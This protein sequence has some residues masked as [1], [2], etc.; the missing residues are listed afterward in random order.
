MS[1]D[2]ALV[3]K[4]PEQPQQSSIFLDSKLN[5]QAQAFASQLASS[6]LVPEAYQGQK[7]HFN[8]MI[9]IEMANRMGLSPL[10]VMQNLTIVRGKPSWSASF[11]IATIQGCGRFEGFK[12]NISGEGDTLAVSCSATDVSTGLEV[13]G[14][15][16]SLETAKA[17]GWARSNKKYQTMPEVMLRYRAASA[18]GRFYIS[19]LL[20][21][22][23]KVEDMSGIDI[24]TIDVRVETPQNPLGVVNGLAARTEVSQE[25]APADSED[26]F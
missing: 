22:L 13:V 20:L 3:P 23:E 6:A 15:V 19:D 1:D 7:G 18:F 8:C 25:Q 12:Y 21:G 10:Q 14:P 11:I 16:V 24:E 4:Q 26:I 2:S 9:A 17:E 5:N